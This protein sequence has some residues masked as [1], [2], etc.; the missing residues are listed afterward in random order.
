M[1]RVPD[2]IRGDRDWKCKPD[3]TNTVSSVRSTDEHRSRKIILCCDSAA[4]RDVGR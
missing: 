4:T 2:S 1:T 3:D